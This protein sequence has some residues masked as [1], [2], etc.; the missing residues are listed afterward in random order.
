M[1]G[2]VRVGV[3]GGENGGDEVAAG[4]GGGRGSGRRWEGT[5]SV[6][7]GFGGLSNAI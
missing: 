3:D 2:V 7:A 4:G 1:I 5:A 6:E